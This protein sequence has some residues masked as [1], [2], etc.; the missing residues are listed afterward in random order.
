M[1]IMRDIVAS[2]R[3]PFSKIVKNFPSFII[4]LFCPFSA[5]FCPFPKKSRHCPH[6]LEFALDDMKC[7]AAE[8]FTITDVGN[9]T[10]INDMILNSFRDLTNSM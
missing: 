8:R 7:T 6:A 3:V 2:M 10:I 1:I 4:V 5:L 9:V